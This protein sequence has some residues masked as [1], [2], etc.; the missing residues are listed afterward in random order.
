MTNEFDLKARE[1]DKNQM[2]VER[3]ISHCPG[4]GK[5]HPPE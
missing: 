2:H 1:W 3:A 5:N 4:N